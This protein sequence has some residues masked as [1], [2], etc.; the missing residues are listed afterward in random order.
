MPIQAKLE[1]TK[2]ADHTWN[3]NLI[4][5][6]EVE[7]TF[8]LARIKN[9]SM[10]LVNYE[11]SQNGKRPVL[12]A[13]FYVNIMGHDLDQWIHFDLETGEQI[14]NFANPHQVTGKYPENDRFAA[15]REKRIVAH[16]LRQSLDKWGQE[17]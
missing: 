13:F 10:T 14:P 8:Y 5:S 16:K 15:R 7:R 3:F 12:S 9:G 11:L 4:V 6:G 2:V 17:K 1:R